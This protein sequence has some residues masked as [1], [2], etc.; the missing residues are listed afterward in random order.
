M[1]IGFGNDIHRLAANR[2]L[3][4]GGVSI[5]SDKGEEAHSDGDVLIHAIIDSILGAKA[6]GDIGSLFPPSDAKWKDA[7][8][9]ELLKAVLELS[10]PEI[11]NLDATITLE[12][13]KLRGYIDEIRKKLSELLAVDISQVSIK[14]KTNEG[15][16]DIGSGNAIKAECVILIN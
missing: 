16:G 5:P 12:R 1:R 10:K 2:P 15:L 3:V 14:A 6:L 7:D 4:I 11:I 13:P 8:S 9:K